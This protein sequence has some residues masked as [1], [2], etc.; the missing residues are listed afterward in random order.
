MLSISFQ[1]GR[2]NAADLIK[3]IRTVRTQIKNSKLTPELFNS[4]NGDDCALE[5]L[6]G[7]DITAEILG[8]EGLANL[9]REVLEKLNATECAAFEKLREMFKDYFELFDRDTAKFQ[10][11]SETHEQFR[12]FVKDEMELKGDAKGCFPAGESLEYSF[13]ALGAVTE[14]V[15]TIAPVM[16]RVFDAD[17]EPVET[18][19]KPEAEP[20]NDPKNPAPVQP[21][22][23][24]IEA[25][26][27]PDHTVETPDEEDEGAVKDIAECVEDNRSLG[28]A[29]KGWKDDA[30]LTDTFKTAKDAYS[31]IAK[32]D[33]QLKQFFNA[34][35]LFRKSV[36]VDTCVADKLAH[37]SSAFYTAVE[38]VK[39][40]LTNA[41]VL[42]DKLTAQRDSLF[43]MVETTW[44]GLDSRRR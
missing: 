2:F 34:R 12:P 19:R 21:E 41:Q 44:H 11:K 37:G 40:L 39:D 27:E 13:D 38:A 26:Q 25:P 22:P 32:T 7:R 10:D 20:I 8:T 17:D 36:P 16:N 24:P 31:M 1:E 28:I 18:V 9:R 43:K 3:N 6:V 33:D 23:K 5:G 14:F 29:L 15:N 35:D 42:A 4:I 30:L